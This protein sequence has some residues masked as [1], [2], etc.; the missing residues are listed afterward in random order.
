MFLTD[1]CIGACL[2]NTPGSWHD[3]RLERFL[4]IDQLMQHLPP[5]YKVAVDTAFGSSARK[6]R[7]LT[8]SELG[9]MS[10]LERSLALTSHSILASL[11]VAAEWGN[12]GLKNC[13]R[14]LLQ[15]G[16][17]DDPIKRGSIAEIVVRLHNLRCRVM[18]VC[19]ITN[20]FN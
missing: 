4:D 10:N 17:A 19:Q 2:T 20:V 8:E 16:E 12:A 15:P 18:N 3:G 13:W 5:Q 9:H 11:R 14:I 6:I 1:G 7:G